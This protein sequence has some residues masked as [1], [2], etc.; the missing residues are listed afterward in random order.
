VAGQVDD[1]VPVD[2]GDRALGHA[3]PVHRVGD[4]PVKRRHGVVDAST[5]VHAVTAPAVVP[6]QRSS[7]ALPDSMRPRWSGM[8]VR[9][10]GERRTP[11]S[12]ASIRGVGDTP[13]SAVRTARN[14][15]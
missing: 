7:A 1:A 15:S 6:A 10:T 11:A 13:I 3:G 4:E 2:D 8:T 9:T 12:N 5:S 14:D